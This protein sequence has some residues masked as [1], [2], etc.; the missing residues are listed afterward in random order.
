MKGFI[1]LFLAL[2]FVAGVYSDITADIYGNS[3]CNGTPQMS[4]T[5]TLNTCKDM[6]QGGST[7]S[8]KPVECNATWAVI[9][10]YMGTTTCAGSPVSVQTG[11]PGTCISDSG[12][13]VKINCFAPSP[14]QP[15]KSGVSSLYLGIG[16]MIVIFV[17][18]LI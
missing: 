17:G 9:N 7:F 12:T 4:M 16:A 13:W 6:S 18:M 11:V 15:I 5:Y 2:T 14:S 10:S 1:S 8:F 3:N